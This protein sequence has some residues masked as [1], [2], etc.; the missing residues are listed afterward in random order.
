MDPTANS[1]KDF[2]KQEIERMINILRK[3]QEM[4]DGVHTFK[5]VDPGTKINSNI[6]YVTVGMNSKYEETQ[7]QVASLFAG[8]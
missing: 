4:G 3:K 6:N 5:R 8:R 1:G 7:F 2:F